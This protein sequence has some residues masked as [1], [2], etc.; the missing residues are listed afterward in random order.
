MCRHIDEY[1][2]LEL[3]YFTIIF[4]LQALSHH[5]SDDGNHSIP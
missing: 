1:I 5:R 4:Q 3:F 2:S